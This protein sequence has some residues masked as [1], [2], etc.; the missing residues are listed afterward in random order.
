MRK[1]GLFKKL[2]NLY[3]IKYYVT[4]LCLILTIEYLKI[5]Q[6]VKTGTKQANVAQAYNEFSP[7]QYSHN[8]IVNIC[9]NIS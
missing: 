2:S 7:T 9:I 6:N 1:F 4:N 8:I 5:K 3:H